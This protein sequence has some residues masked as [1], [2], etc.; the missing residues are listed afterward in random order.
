MS[1]RLML[2]MSGFVILTALVLGA[3]YY[4]IHRTLLSVIESDVRNKGVKVVA[5]YEYLVSPKTLVFDLRD[6][7]GEKSPLDIFR[8]F[9][10]FSAAQKDHEYELIK[11]SFRGDS[12][13]ILKGD[14]FKKLGDEF[15]T[16]NP[17]YTIRTFPEHLFRPD[18]SAAFGVWTGG[19]IGVLGKQ[20]EDFNEF[21][22]EWY[23]NDLLK[24][25]R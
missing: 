22:R 15:G 23:V 19:L 5:Y 20:M 25:G 14:Y 13:F 24:T 6:V 18:G 9:L 10:Q 12:K 3:N 17:V 1:R 11:L 21:H 4:F 8:V 16:Q 2:L 7:E